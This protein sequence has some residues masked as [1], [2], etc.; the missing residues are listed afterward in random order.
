MCY[1]T[2]LNFS[3]LGIIE[4]EVDVN[5][6]ST[7]LNGIS[8]PIT[9]TREWHGSG[10]HA[11]YRL[12][13]FDHIGHYQLSITVRGQNSSSHVV[14]YEE[15]I[16]LVTVYVAPP[17]NPPC[18]PLPP[19]SPMPPSPP[20]AI[21]L[22]SDL[23]GGA[24][25]PSD[26]IS[27]HQFQEQNVTLYMRSAPEPTAEADSWRQQSTCY[28][29][30][31]NFSGLGVVDFNVEVNVTGT[32][33]DATSNQWTL[34]QEVTSKDS[35]TFRVCG[36]DREGGY[37]L[38]VAVHATDGTSR[39]VFMKEDIDI[40]SVYLAPPPLIPFLPPPPPSPPSPFPPP[41]ITIPVIDPV[42]SYFLVLVALVVIVVCGWYGTICMAHLR[43]IRWTV[44]E[45]IFDRQFGILEHA[46]RVNPDG[47]HTWSLV[48][49]QEMPLTD[50]LHDLFAT[51][52]VVER[53]AEERC[54]DAPAA[55]ST[56][57]IAA[58]LRRA[59]VDASA[60]GVAGKQHSE[61]VTESRKKLGQGVGQRRIPSAVVT[62]VLER[63]P[64]RQ[65]AKKDWG[66]VPSSAGSA[67]TAC[68]YSV[69][70][71]AVAALICYSNAARACKEYKQHLGCSSAALAAFGKPPFQGI[72]V[73]K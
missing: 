18:P 34:T 41:Y 51:I 43:R 45:R 26:E 35:A 70:M 23:T 67:A 12:C 6:S 8:S 11:T 47:L 15:D 31:L 39:E 55:S 57:A 37:R 16:D 46:L 9:L 63:H 4:F 10:D 27:L 25:F 59:A 54:V 3:S 56:P 17:P 33:L 24:H 66:A 7:P 30:L 58:A 61:L 20:P 32:T 50:E 5:I 53:F 44:R 1:D 40:V 36:F 21:H 71:L 29:T 65:L 49:K 2:L 60:C 14:F 62:W 28:D 13:G 38:S 68:C 52:C 72:A 64:W 69:A 48:L 22:T 19:L 73:Q 42:P